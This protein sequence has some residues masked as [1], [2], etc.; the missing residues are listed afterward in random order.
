[1]KA[2]E[3]SGLR[4]SVYIYLPT[5]L[6]N[7]LTISLILSSACIP[8]QISVPHHITQHCSCFMR[9]IWLPRFVVDCESHPSKVRFPKD[10]LARSS[11]LHVAN[12]WPQQSYLAASHQAIRC[13]PHNVHR[14]VEVRHLIGR[15]AVASYLSP[16]PVASYFT[17]WLRPL[18]TNCC[19]PQCLA[20]KFL[21]GSPLLIPQ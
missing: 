10:H 5:Y 3:F 2:N 16:I 20:T 17:H 8:L 14:A 19:N 1:M 11:L 21:R 15:A 18:V 9:C 13:C 7:Y 12:S 4:E 6:T